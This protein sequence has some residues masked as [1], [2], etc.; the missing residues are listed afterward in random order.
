MEPGR[1]RQLHSA[2]TS[3]ALPQHLVLLKRFHKIAAAI[4]PSPDFSTFPTCPPPCQVTFTL[5]ESFRLEDLLRLQLHKY[6]AAGIATRVWARVG[7]PLDWP[8]H[9]VSEPAHTRLVSP[10]CYGLCSAMPVAGMPRTWERLWTA[11]RR[12]RRWKRCVGGCWEE[13]GS[14]LEGM[15]PVGG[16]TGM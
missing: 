8:A 5:D 1:A 14:R 6:V 7:C 11:H 16:C 9:A 13:E 4:L 10:P 3:G 12:R 15:L 2:E